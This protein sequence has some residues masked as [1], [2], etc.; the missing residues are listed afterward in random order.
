[1]NYKGR[2]AE[3]EQAWSW[4]L[5]LGVIG[6]LV[7]DSWKEEVGTGNSGIWAKKLGREIERQ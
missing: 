3:I 7:G 1:M 4:R 5:R 6:G 2:V